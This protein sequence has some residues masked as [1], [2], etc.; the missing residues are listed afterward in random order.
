[1]LFKKFRLL[2]GPVGP[3]QDVKTIMGKFGEHVFYT[4]R[5]PGNHCVGAFAYQI[6]LG[7]GGH[8]GGVKC[9]RVIHTLL[10]EA[11]NANHKILV[12]VGADYGEEF[13]PFR[14]RQVVSKPFLQ[15]AVVELDSRFISNLGDF[16]SFCL[17]ITL[18][19]SLS[20]RTCSP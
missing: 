16:K 1:M 4:G 11:R 5:L 3:R 19:Y 20:N 8:T 10:N 18:T 2:I 15:D 12:E 9:P 13:E 17:P 14:Q 7:L 6:K